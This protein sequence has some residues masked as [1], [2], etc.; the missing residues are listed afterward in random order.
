MTENDKINGWT[1]EETVKTAENLMEVE[2]DM[3]KW[4]VIR[5]IRDFAEYFKD[6]LDKYKEIGTVEEC[7]AAL[8]KQTPKTPKVQKIE[9]YRY[10]KCQHCMTDTVL[11][12][13]MIPDY[14]PRCGGRLD[15]S[16]KE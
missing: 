4:D 7:R 9:D 16:N 15:W 2:K 3:Y 14:C 6:E 12:G 13:G 5:H 10:M 11:Y 8:W 1:F